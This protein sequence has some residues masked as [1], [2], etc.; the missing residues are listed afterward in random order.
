[1]EVSQFASQKCKTSKSRQRRS[2]DKLIIGRIF[3]KRCHRKIILP[4]S[5][6]I[7]GKSCPKIERKTKTYT[8][9]IKAKQIY[10]K[11]LVQTSETQRYPASSVRRCLDGEGRSRGRIPPYPNKFPLSAIPKFSMA[12]RNLSLYSN[13]FRTLRS[14]S[15]FYGHDECCPQKGPGDECQHN[16]IPGRLAAVGANQERLSRCPEK[17]SEYFEKFGLF[18]EPREVRIDSTTNSNLS[19]SRVENQHDGDQTS[20]GKSN[21]IKLRS[22]KSSDLSFRYLSQ[23][24]R[25]PTR[26][27][28]VRCPVIRRMC[29]QKKVV[30][31]DNIFL[32]K[33]PENERQSTEDPSSVLGGSN[34]VDKFRQCVPM[35]SNET[36]TSLLNSL[37]G[38]QR[39]RVGRSH[40]QWKV[41]RR[42][43]VSRG[44]TVPHKRFRNPCGTKNSRIRNS[45]STSVHT[46]L[47]GQCNDRVFDQQERFNEVETNNLSCGTTTES[48][49]E[50]EHSFGNEA[51]PWA[52]ECGRR[53]SVQGDH[54]PHGVGNPS[55]GLAKNLRLDTR[56][57][58]GSDGYALQSKSPDVRVSL[59]SSGSLGSR[60][61]NCGLE[62]VVDSLCI[63][64][65]NH[66]ERGVG[67]ST[68]FQRNLGR[69]C[70]TGA[71]RPDPQPDVLRSRINTP[72]DAISQTKGSGSVDARL[73]TSILELDR[74][75][76]LKKMWIEKYGLEVASKLSKCNRPQTDNQQ[77]IAWKALQGWLLKNP[78][79]PFNKSSL[80]EFMIYLFESRGLQPQTVKNCRAALTE[81][82]KL[83]SNIDLSSEEFKDLDKAFFLLKPAETRHMPNWSLSKVLKLLSSQ[84]YKNESCSDYN[85]LKKAIFLLSLATGNRVSEINAIQREPIR[86]LRNPDGIGF[87]VKPGFL[88]KNQRYGKS[89]PDIEIV[90]ITNVNKQLC[91]VETIKK[92]IK[93]VGKKKGPLFVNSRTKGPLNPSSL[94]KLMCMVIDEADP[95]KIPRG[96]DVRRA[97]ASL[98]WSRGLP[99]S[100]ITR[101]AF[102]VSSNTFINRYMA[103]FSGNGVALNTQG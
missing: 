98:A 65:S 32:A 44:E 71:P 64:S 35:E 102:W 21:S 14:S 93:R 17:G 85:L 87:V 4:P 79:K 29:S 24:A 100:E 36:P 99:M 81:P 58:G 66:A 16:C 74:I 53:R 12:K 28:G 47:Y 61:Q 11:D 52:S 55:F 19:R 94:S 97:A 26:L 83:C 45:P 5:V 31:S 68:D 96:H 15:R 56:D 95:G 30:K 59:R 103:N 9:F 70:Q 69:S 10:K 8:R 42:K 2:R 57:S 1:M 37:D 88:Y 6:S 25:E 90:K 43:L 76:F 49:E 51:C 89:P 63:P 3:R 92:Y 7:K 46:G 82:L 78:E 75:S 13:A 54:S 91:P 50:R 67:E 33:I 86:V 80:L 27:H 73:R 23:T 38:C 18:S 39:G 41:G 101:R 77:Q 72:S 40:Y 22:P 48:V 84:D 20:C 60:C 62:H 34:L